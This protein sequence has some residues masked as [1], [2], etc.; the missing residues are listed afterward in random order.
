MNNL[1][2]STKSDVFDKES[3]NFL[4][5]GDSQAKDIFAALKYVNVSNSNKYSFQKLDDIYFKDIITDFNK[6]M[7]SVKIFGDT[8]INL[9]KL[10]QKII[11]S[12]VILLA[13]LWDNKTSNYVIELSDYL[14]KAFDKKINNSRIFI[15]S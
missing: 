3:T 12:D 4:I 8:Q 7:N 1:K 2:K 5:I 13:G 6:D 11:D 15:F 14:A 9:T 10:R